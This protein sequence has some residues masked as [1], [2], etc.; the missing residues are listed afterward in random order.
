MDGSYPSNEAAS[1]IGEFGT[2]YTGS[3][4]EWLD[5]LVDYL[6]AIEQRNSFF[7]CLNPNSGDT[8][9]LLQDDWTTEETGK[10]EALHRL[11]PAPSKI[12]WDSSAGSVCITFDGAGNSTVNPTS[13][14]TDTPT[15][16]PTESMVDSTTSTTMDV[17]SSTESRSS[18]TSMETSVSTTDNE[19]IESTSSS[20]TTTTIPVDEGRSSGHR[21][22]IFGVVFVMAIGFVVNL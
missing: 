15:V 2:K 16:A 8:G 7:W 4:V 14:T 18:S 19:L 5:D 17:V 22:G 6:G 10:L 12:T 13:T 20:S 11:Q 9:G 1:V 3:M 21:L